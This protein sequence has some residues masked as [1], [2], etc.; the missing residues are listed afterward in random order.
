MVKLE[1]INKEKQKAKSYQNIA[2]FLY[3]KAKR[4]HTQS[5]IIC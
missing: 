5:I 1:K 3:K 2:I 4:A